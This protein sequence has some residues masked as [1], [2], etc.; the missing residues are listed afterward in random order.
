MYRVRHLLVSRSTTFFVSPPTIKGR[1]PEPWEEAIGDT[2]E[3]VARQ[4]RTVVE[5]AAKMNAMGIDERSLAGNN[6]PIADHVTTMGRDKMRLLPGVPVA[7]TGVA[8]AAVEGE[9]GKKREP[10]A[11][12]DLPVF[13]RPS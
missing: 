9:V 13:N 1:P 7:P 8:A 4:G 11:T 2:G 6:N 12:C 3:R 10:E 5:Y